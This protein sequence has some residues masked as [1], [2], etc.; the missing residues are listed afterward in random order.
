[1]KKKM[2]EFL[3]SD[4]GQDVVGGIVI[5]GFIMINVVLVHCL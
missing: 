3:K 5:M 4:L 1:M 2:V